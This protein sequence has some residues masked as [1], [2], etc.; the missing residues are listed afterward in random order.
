MGRVFEPQIGL[1]DIANGVCECLPKPLPLYYC[2]YATCTWKSI[3]KGHKDIG[4]YMQ[5]IY[6]L[7]CGW[8]C[9]KSCTL[10]SF[11][12]NKCLI[13]LSSGRE[14]KRRLKCRNDQK[15]DL[16][17]KKSWASSQ[18]LTQFWEALIQPSDTLSAKG[19]VLWAGLPIVEP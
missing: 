9:Y 10:F 17:S 4:W 15:S 16:T 1:H 6:H 3:L 19:L 5:S 13:L 8:Q 18:A 12:Q 7:A 14:F 11:S 2:V